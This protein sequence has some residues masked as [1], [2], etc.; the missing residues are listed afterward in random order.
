[1]KTIYFTDN[2]PLRVRVLARCQAWRKRFTKWLDG[3]SDFYSMIAE[4]E[5]TRRQVVYVNIITL[6]LLVAAVIVEVKTFL[7]LVLMV[8]ASVVAFLLQKCDEE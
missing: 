8:L 6:C 7:A 3:K 4:F 5:V 2:A 1:M